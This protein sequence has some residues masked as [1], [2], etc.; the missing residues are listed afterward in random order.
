[1]VKTVSVASLFHQVGRRN[2]SLCNKLLAFMY[3]CFLSELHM[4]IHHIFIGTET[5][6][7]DHK[8]IEGSLECKLVVS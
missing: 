5:P 6:Q 1:M 8:V 7:H 2:K 4:L 3:L